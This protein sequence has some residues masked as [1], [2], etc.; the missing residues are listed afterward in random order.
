MQTAL[1]QSRSASIPASWIASVC[2]PIRPRLRR[3]ASVANFLSPE[4]WT[5]AFASGFKNSLCDPA[6]A[7]RLEFDID[8]AAGG[9]CGAWRD[10]QQKMHQEIREGNRG[11]PCPIAEPLKLIKRGDVSAYPR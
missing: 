3:F 10:V 5:S 11:N 6:P 1:Y 9:A 8:M 2:G 7:E 4:C